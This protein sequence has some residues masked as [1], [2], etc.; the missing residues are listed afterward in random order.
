M[1]RGGIS[2]ICNAYGEAYNKL[3]KSDYANKPTLYIIYLDD[4]NLYGHSM[5]QLLPIEILFWVNI[6]DFNLC[7]YS[8]DSPIGYLS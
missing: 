6:K 4:N 5:M 1:I 8:N 3:L 2:I 7:K